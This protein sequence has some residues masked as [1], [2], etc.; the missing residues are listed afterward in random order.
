MRIVFMR[1]NP[2]S[3]DP[4]VEKEVGSLS[5]N[6]ENIHVLAWD[7]S[8]KYPQK[9]QS[10]YVGKNSCQ[11]T[12]FGIPATYGGG[13]KT[14]LLPLISFQVKLFNWLYRNKN[15]YDVIHACDFDTAL[16]GYICAKLF[17]K[18]V[19]YDMFDCVT[20]P[21]HGPKLV[22]SMVERIDTAIMN[23]VNALIICTE[24]RKKQITKSSPKKLAVIHNTPS[25]ENMQQGK[26]P[27]KAN[28]IKIV[29]VGVLS[30]GRFIEQLIDVVIKNPRYELH[31]G[32][33]G[34][35]ENK[36]KQIADENENIIFYGKLPYEKTIA[37]EHSCDIM[38][39]IYNPEVSN[40]F[41]AAPNK[42]YEAL[43]L[44]KP[45]IM[46]KN[47]GMSE[48]VEEYKIGEVID[49]NVESLENAIASLVNRKDDWPEISRK[50]KQLYNKYYSWDEMERR[51]VELY[52]NLEREPS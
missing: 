31:I 29:Y 43:M 4:R 21:F 25:M 16:I 33:F 17:R 39:A 11:I 41:F 15:S 51:L 35:L 32:G 28:K 20:S 6:F 46:V 5:K 30:G 7:R 13:F 45:L 48:I 14:N 3:P 1:S 2:V 38:T 44:G 40:H 23:R 8:E 50:M 18:K 47:T 34:L 24:K 52:R 26:I 22:G 10:L 27:L 9:D 36:I 12:R 19:V 42:F 49:Y 37:L